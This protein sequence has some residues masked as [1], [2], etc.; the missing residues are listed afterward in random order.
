MWNIDYYSRQAKIPKPE[1]C[2]CQP[3]GRLRKL[4][5]AVEV[6]ATSL[7]RALLTGCTPVREQ[8]H[9]RHPQEESLPRSVPV[10]QR[11]RLLVKR[12]QDGFALDTKRLGCRGWVRAVLAVRR[13]CGRLGCVGV[14]RRVPR[15]PRGVEVGSV[16]NFLFELVVESLRRGGSALDRNGGNRRRQG[17][18]D[19]V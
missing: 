11:P 16:R 19:G 13:G 14:T 3:R 1:K 15:V 8:W 5:I 4:E 17:G 10:V 7:V 18:R 12:T 2:S 6:H 9:R